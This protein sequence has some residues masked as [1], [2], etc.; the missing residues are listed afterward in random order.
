M[1]IWI[2]CATGRDRRVSKVRRWLLNS[3]RGTWRRGVLQMHPGKVLSGSPRT[4]LHGLC[5]GQVLG[6]GGNDELHILFR[7][8]I[9]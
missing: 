9:Q 8:H 2:L 4:Q 5:S 7:W 3:W 6:R 1:S